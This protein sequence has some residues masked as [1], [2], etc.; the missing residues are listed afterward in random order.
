MAYLQVRQHSFIHSCPDASLHPTHVCEAQILSVCLKMRLSFACM[1]FAGCVDAGAQAG[2][3]WQPGP[4]E[5][6]HTTQGPAIRQ[7]QVRRRC[8]VDWEEG[9]LDVSRGAEADVS[10]EGMLI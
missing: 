8:P 4:L 10:G 3:P 5:L 7:R 6:P 2:V 9:C 1:C